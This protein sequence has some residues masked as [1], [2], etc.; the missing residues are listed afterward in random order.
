MGHPIP[1]PHPHQRGLHAGDALHTRQRFGLTV[2]KVVKHSQTAKRSP[3]TRRPAKRAINLSLSADVLNAAKSLRINVSQIC[4]TAVPVGRRRSLD[5][6]R[7]TQQRL[8]SLFKFLAQDVVSRH[9]LKADR[10]Y[11]SY[12]KFSK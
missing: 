8:A 6:R 10:E 3:N 7:Y 11:F 5:C 2:A 12:V 4:H 9:M 1:P